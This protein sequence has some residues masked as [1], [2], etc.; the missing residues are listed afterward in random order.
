MYVSWDPVRDLYL[1]SPDAMNMMLRL[2][3]SSITWGFLYAVHAGWVEYR[4]RYIFLVWQY[5]LL[6]DPAKPVCDWQLHA[7]SKGF[8]E[9]HEGHLLFV[10]IPTRVGV[11]VKL[12][13]LAA[14]G[15]YPRFRNREADGKHGFQYLIMRHGHQPMKSM[16]TETWTWKWMIERYPHVY[17]FGVR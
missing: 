6:L 1:Y 4:W 11:F 3:W 12:S 5:S 2:V 16:H 7:Y 13:S 17:L 15:F 10:G 14:F 9:G 8:H